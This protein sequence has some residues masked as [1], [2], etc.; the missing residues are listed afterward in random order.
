[1]TS[2]ESKFFAFLGV[3]LT[4]IGFLLALLMKRKDHYVIYY[5]K[6]GLILF[7]FGIL[8]WILYFISDTFNLVNAD[9][10]G[11]GFALLFIIAWTTGWIYSLSGYEKPIPVI[12]KLADKIKI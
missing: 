7:F 10:V 12:G 9:A 6:Q 1:M 3:F 4:L 2:G 11:T 8:L 5:G